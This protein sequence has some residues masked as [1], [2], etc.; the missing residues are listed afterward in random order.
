MESFYGKEENSQS[1]FVWLV[2]RPYSFVT[3]T[4]ENAAERSRSLIAVTRKCGYS[5]QKSRR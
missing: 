2:S 1:E 4:D 5:G 3:M